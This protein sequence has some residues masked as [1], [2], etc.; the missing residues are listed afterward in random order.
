MPEHLH[1][2]D[3]EIV[4]PET[5]H[6]KS[7][8]NVRAL[9]WSAVILGIFA[10]LTHVGLWLMY[11]GLVKYEQKNAAPPLSAIQRSP[12]A[13]VPQNQPLLQPFPRKDPAGNP[14]VAP[15][16]ST[17]VTDLGDMRRAEDRALSSY[18]WV[19]RQKGIVRIP[20]EEA[21]KLVLERGLPQ[22]SQIATPLAV[23]AP[24]APA[25][26]PAAMQQGDSNPASIRAQPGQEAPQ[27]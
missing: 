5:H 23:P 16:R 10:V 22:Q 6:E 17:P 19:D 4:N 15:Y 27:H 11:R 3:D 21:K 18:G 20:I 12:D 26:P 2:E 13:G 1:Y 7:D 14:A 8:V 24:A 25:L 9:L